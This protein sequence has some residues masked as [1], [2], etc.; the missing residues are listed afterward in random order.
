[1]DPD[2]LAQLLEDQ[3]VAHLRDVLEFHGVPG[4]NFAADVSDGLVVPT[5]NDQ[6]LTFEFEQDPVTNQT[7]VFVRTPNTE[8]SEVF[9]F[10]FE[11]S[12][13]IAHK[14]REV[15]LPDFWDKNLPTAI[16]LLDDE[17]YSIFKDLFALSQ[18][19][20]TS[21]LEDGV[22]TVLAANNQAFLDALGGQEGVD[23]LLQT[24][25]AAR[26]AILAANIIPDTVLPFL[27][28]ESDSQTSVEASDGSTVTVSTQTTTTDDGQTTTLFR[29]NDIIAS[30]ID[31]LANNGLV[32]GMDGVILPTSETLD[33]LQEVIDG[34]A[35]LTTLSSVL[36][37]AGFDDMFGDPTSDP[38]VTLCSPVNSAFDNMDPDRLAQLLEDQFVAHLRDVLEF[39]GVP[40][41]TFAAQVTDGL[42]APTLNDQELTFEFEQD[43]VTNQTLV[44]VRTPNTEGSEVFEFDFEAS[45]GIAHKVR[46]VFLPDFW[47]KNLTTT[48]ALL[49]DEQY[50]IFKDLFALSQDALTSTLEDGVATV[51]AANNQA[52]LDALGGQEGVDALLQTEDAARDAILAANIIPDT[53]LPFLNRESDSQTSVEASDGSTVT[54]STQTTTTDDG[55]TTTLFRFNDIIASD[56]DMLA[57]NGLVHG[58]DGVILPSETP[59]TPMP[60]SNSTVADIACNTDGSFSG[61]STLCA[62]LQA[63][64]LEA[65][66]RDGTYTVFAPTDDAFANLPNGTVDALL[67]DI[68]SLTNVLLFHAVADQEIFSTDL[69]CTQLIEMANGE[70]SRTVCSDG[71]IHQKGAG[72]PR[73]NMPEIITTDI[74]ASNGV[75]HVV[76]QVMLS[77]DVFVDGGEAPPVVPP[78]VGDCASIADIACT[79]PAFSTLCAAVQAVPGLAE[80]LSSADNTSTVFA[81]T[82]DAFG[83][84]PNGT[85]AALLEDTP[86]LADILLFHA[87]ADRAVFSSDLECTQLIEMA[88]GEDSRTV[89]SDGKIHQKG[90]GNPRDNMPEIIATDIEACN[91]VIHIVSEVMLP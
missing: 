77:S 34:E 59:E 3:F 16:A 71:K 42:V 51:L 9:E 55:Q 36:T 65:A 29:F 85:V 72:N 17:Q 30:D 4:K 28:R 56:I 48:I 37:L 35:D 73:D 76:S 2:R 66:L 33:T 61:F 24:E 74:V 18:D 58:M 32:H 14:V 83:N 82:D 64:G 86:A 31:M 20:L 81:P 78:P 40:G 47:D 38:Q 27:N 6:Q 50:S 90:A 80:V 69:E 68:P 5:L 22:A 43:P 45:N 88:N 91:G 39:H 70:D 23:A 84:L 79:T 8:G 54:V 21:T 44:F 75:V 46:E 10:D 89:C 15:F 26:D 53:V 63:A 11:A 67:N 19:A 49:D 62:A 60:P 12:N 7:L 52:F 57:N 1:M 13:G 25:D 87:V 41:K